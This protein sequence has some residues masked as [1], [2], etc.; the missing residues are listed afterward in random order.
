[1]MNG[2]LQEFVCNMIAKGQ[3]RYGDVSGTICLAESQ[4]T[5]N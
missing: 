4:M 5:I 1:M 2:T 3:I